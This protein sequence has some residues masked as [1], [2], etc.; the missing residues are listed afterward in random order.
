VPD[1]DLHPAAEVLVAEAVVGADA[2]PAGHLPALHH[3]DGCLGRRDQVVRARGVDVDE[4]AALPTGSDDDVPAD[5]EGEAAEHLL[6]GQL[7]V[8]PDQLPDPPGEDFV[9]GHAAD[10]TKLV[11]Q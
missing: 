7:R 3:G 8:G 4:H 11:G 10:R 1:T 5:E 2:Q 9:I 6:L